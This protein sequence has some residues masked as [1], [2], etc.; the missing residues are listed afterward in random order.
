VLSRGLAVEQA[1]GG[2]SIEDMRPTS[3]RTASGLERRLAGLQHAALR[4]PVRFYFGHREKL[5]YLIVGGWNT[6]FGYGIWALLQLLIGDYVPYLVVL[7]LAWP[8]AV[9]NGYLGYRYLVFR[10]RGPVPS[11]LPRFSLVYLVTLVV[12]LAVLPVALRVLPFNIYVVEGLFAG[13]VVVGSYLGHKHFSF[14]AA[15]APASGSRVGPGDGPEQ[16][17]PRARRLRP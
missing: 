2:A 1:V 8:L 9:L 17:P 4:G 15:P 12:N 13:L 7:V 5:L 11:E 6:I 3:T 16:S 10:S 14:R